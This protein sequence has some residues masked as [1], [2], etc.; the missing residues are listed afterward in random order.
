MST[1]EEE[2]GVHDL[3][4]QLGVQEI[5]AQMKGVL[6]IHHK[7]RQNKEQLIDHVISHAPSEHI[8]FLCNA[9]QEKLKAAAAKR[10]ER[11]EQRMG[12]A[13]HKH[14]DEAP[15]RCTALDNNYNPSGFLQFPSDE[16]LKE[17]YAGFFEATLSSALESGTC[18]VCACSS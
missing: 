2:F 14:T 6:K 10:D 11:K 8:E 13:K 4:V 17:C 18:G 15:Q 12:G 9:G 5:I 3:L 16:E 7:E 1:V